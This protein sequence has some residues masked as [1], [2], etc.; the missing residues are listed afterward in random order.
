MRR[1]GC[2][3]IEFGRAGTG[4]LWLYNAE[5]EETGLNGLLELNID[6]YLTFYGI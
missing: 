1:R 2:G 5:Y 4:D 6:D 3:E